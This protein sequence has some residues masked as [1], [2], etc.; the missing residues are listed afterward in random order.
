MVNTQ[1]FYIKKKLLNWQK[2]Q[3]LSTF[4]HLLIKV[5]IRIAYLIY[6][7]FFMTNYSLYYSAEK[8]K[9]Q[10]WYLELSV[11][12]REEGY[13]LK[14]GLSPRVQPDGN[15]EGSGHNY[16]NSSSNM[17][18]IPFLTMIYWF[19]KQFFS[20]AASLLYKNLS[21]FLLK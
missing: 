13:T 16:P 21:A 1:V 3:I 10:L 19:F 12:G 15:P 2:N 11:L 4:L 20:A 18:I 14:Y 6:S 8:R 9:Q 5:N 7:R 17:N